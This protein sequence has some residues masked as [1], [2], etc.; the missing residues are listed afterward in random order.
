LLKT[1]H[2][3]KA[4]KLP[5]KIFEVADVC[6]IDDSEETGARNERRACI[7][8]SND[9]KTGIEIVHG[10]MDLIMKKF[11]QAPDPEIG[12]SIVESHHPTYFERRQVEVMLRGEHIG[13]FG[14]LHPEVL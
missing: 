9:K 14:V 6:L 2:A 8:Y 7:L 10:A 5:H 3:N 1:I 11:G 12:Y 4:E 13:H